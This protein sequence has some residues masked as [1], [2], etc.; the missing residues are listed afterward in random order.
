MVDIDKFK[1][2]SFYLGMNYIG[3]FKSLMVKHEVVL[4]FCFQLSDHIRRAQSSRVLLLQVQ[5][6]MLVVNPPPPVTQSF[7]EDPQRLFF[8]IVA[9][10][11]CILSPGVAHTHTL[12]LTLSQVRAHT[13][14]PVR[15]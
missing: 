14:F 7:N 12:T 5:A 15:R 2:I 1:F 4:P 13:H 10:H 9:L 11:A 3:T 6:R 8:V